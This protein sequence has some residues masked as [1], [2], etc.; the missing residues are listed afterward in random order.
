MCSAGE[1]LSC[2][3]NALDVGRQSSH[4]TARPMSHVN[5]AEATFTPPE[6]PNRCRVASPS[7]TVEKLRAQ[8]LPWLLA[9][10]IHNHRAIMVAK[11]DAHRDDDRER[12]GAAP[13]A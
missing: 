11:A 12:L 2:L 4:T 8:R 6:L 13:Q 3:K 9:R 1:M 5:T 7:S 10:A